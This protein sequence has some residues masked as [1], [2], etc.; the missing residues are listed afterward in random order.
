MSKLNLAMWS[1]PRNLS[2]ALMYSFANRPDF[3]AIDEPFYACYL[4]KTGLDHPMGD[5]V[6]ASQPTDANQVIDGLL[7][8]RDTHYYQKHMTQHML[9]DIPRAWIENVTN[10]FLIR[11][12]NRVLASF[13]A[14][15]DNPTPD[16]IGF[17]QQFELYE[18]LVQR[19]LSPI[20]IDSADIRRDPR[21]YLT[22]LCTALGIDF[23]PEMLAWPKGPKPFDGVWAP[24]WYGAVHTST[25]FAQAE[26]EIPNLASDLQPIAK[27]CMG[28]YT[29]MMDVK[30]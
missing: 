27:T 17:R 21:T 16:D 24:H 7:A 30:L 20:V 8:Q 13:S 4:T 1:G 3:Q 6:I 26:G 19:G 2:T 28:Y 18:H 10:V 11:H 22:K 14:K 29:K 5:A 9:P 12:P 23:M 15:Y 25:G